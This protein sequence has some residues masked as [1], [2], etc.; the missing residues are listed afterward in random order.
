MQRQ[1]VYVIGRGAIPR[2]SMLIS[3]AP[4]AAFIKRTCQE[5]EWVAVKYQRGNGS[6][7]YYVESVAVPPDPLFILKTQL[8]LSFYATQTGDA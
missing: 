7:K 5:Y 4:K 1:P 6:L 8:T 3:L 2:L